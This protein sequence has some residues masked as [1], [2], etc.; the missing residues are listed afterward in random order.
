MN[1]RKDP[2]GAGKRRLTRAPRPKEFTW[3]AFLIRLAVAIV[4]LNIIAGILAWY[5]LSRPRH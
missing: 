5:F 4:L 2:S 3:T 1:G